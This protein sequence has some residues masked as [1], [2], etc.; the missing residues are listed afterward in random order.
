MA[1]NDW[2]GWKLLTERIGDRVQLVGDDLFVTNP[3]ILRRGIDG[4]HRQLDPDQAQP[5]RHAHRDA[6]RDRASPATPATARSSRTAPARPRTRSSPT[7]P[8]PPAPARSRPAPP[9]AP[10]ASPS[11]TSCSASRRN[12]ATARATPAARPSPSDTSRYPRT[13]RNTC[14][15]EPGAPGAGVVLRSS[16]TRLR[17]PRQ[18]LASG[19]SI[20]ATNRPGAQSSAQSGVNSTPPKRRKSHWNAGLRMA[21]PGLEPGTPRFS[22]CALPTE[23]SRRGGKTG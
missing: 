16:L 4:R 13:P 19:L 20:A 10:S 2:D 22:V 12:S 5:D 11:T 3:A 6:R 1:E 21:R 18:A 9:P 15:L 23:L 14:W 17:N 8:S 7:S